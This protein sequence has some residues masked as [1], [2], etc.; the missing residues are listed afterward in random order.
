MNCIDSSKNLLLKLQNE[1]KRNTATLHMTAN[2]NVM[3]NTAS[4]FLSS[5]L[6]YRY[7]SD[8]YEKE[9]NLAEAKY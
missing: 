7:Y 2:E 5:N 6:S 4:S 9:D 8:T 1:E 3:S